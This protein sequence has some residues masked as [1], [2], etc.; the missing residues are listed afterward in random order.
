V[1]YADISETVILTVVSCD[2]SNLAI[3]YW[4]N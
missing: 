3:H 4:C 1:H 2:G